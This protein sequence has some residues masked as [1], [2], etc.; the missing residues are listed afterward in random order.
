MATQ[1]DGLTCSMC[2]VLHARNTNHSR[3]V[4]CIVPMLLAAAAVAQMVDKTYCAMKIKL[5]ILHYK[6]L[7][8]IEL[9]LLRSR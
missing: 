6:D 8:C 4:L 7:I 2:Y 9:H 1:D 5:V 3:L